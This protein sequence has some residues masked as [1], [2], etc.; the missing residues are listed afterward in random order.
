VKLLLDTHLLLWTARDSPKLSTAARDLIGDPENT[1]YVSVISLWEVA[2]KGSLGRS[3]F[4]WDVRSLRRG[5]RDRAFV[6][7]A[8]DGAHA[9]AIALL[10]GIHRDPFDRMLVA[11]AMVEGLTLITADPVLGSYPGP[12]LRV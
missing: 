12:I 2:I 8:V 7:L 1:R 4:Q 6:E 11:Q 5:M 3:D 9:V 10:P